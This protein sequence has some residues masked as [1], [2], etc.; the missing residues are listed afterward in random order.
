MLADRV[1]EEL[2]K[3]ELLP[4]AR[5]KTFREIREA[6]LSD[7]RIRYEMRPLYRSAI[8]VIL[9]S[10]PKRKKAGSSFPVTPDIREG[11]PHPEDDSWFVLI[12]GDKKIL[13][14][15]GDVWEFECSISGE[16]GILAI[17]LNM[18]LELE[19]DDVPHAIRERA[20]EIAREYFKKLKAEEGTTIPQTRQRRM[21]KKKAK[22]GDPRQGTLL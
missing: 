10:R 21:R 8:G 20:A 14:C 13:V 11:L 17:R 6:I 3:N 4:S 1:S 9:G 19:M 5:R 2:R 22:R 15:S 18:P 16:T 7:Y 12:L